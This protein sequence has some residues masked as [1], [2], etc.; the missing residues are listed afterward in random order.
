MKFIASS[1]APLMRSVE[2]VVVSPDGTVLVTNS[3]SLKFEDATND[4]L[5]GEQRRPDEFRQGH[6][7]RCNVRDNVVSGAVVVFRVLVVDG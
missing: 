5:T 4:E 6:R 1:V 7:I 3:G 2:T